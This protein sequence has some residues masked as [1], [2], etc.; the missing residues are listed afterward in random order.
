[1]RTF[2]QYIESRGYN[3]IR[4]E[5]WINNGSIDFADGDVGDYN[6]EGLAIQHVF[7][8]HSDNVVDLAEELG[9]EVTSPDKWGEV[10][11]EAV[12]EILNQIYE[13]QPNEQS[14]MQRLQ[15]N[16]ECLQILMGGG[17]ASSYVMKYEGWIAVRNNNIEL[18]GYDEKKRKSLASGL[19]EILESEGI[20]D[21]VPPEEIDFTLHDHKTNKSS[22]VTLADIENPVPV[23]RPAQPLMTKTHSKFNITNPD[24]TENLPQTIKSNP[25]SGRE[26]WRGT[27]ENAQ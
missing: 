17:D 23:V 9:I 25:I 12:A 2:L 11:T 4:G 20:E 7:H 24:T 26:N 10:D 13:K 5:F 14:L 16:R 3:E 6:H 1:M 18:Y 8:T 22:Y 19:G 21:H 15:I 27:S